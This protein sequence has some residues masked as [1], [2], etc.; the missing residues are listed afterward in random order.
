MTSSVLQ[1]PTVPPG[2]G[3]FTQHAAGIVCTKTD[4]TVDKN[5]LV[6]SR[7]GN[8]TPRLS[9]LLTTERASEAGAREEHMEDQ[10][11]KARLFHSPTNSAPKS[12]C[13]C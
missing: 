4:L 2:P 11:S 5:D 8:T 1:G 9:L 7:N 3:T 13:R 10:G 6:G 12:Y